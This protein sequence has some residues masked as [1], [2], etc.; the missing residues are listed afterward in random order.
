V[1]VVARFFRLRATIT[2]FIAS[3]FGWENVEFSC[4]VGLR[5]GVVVWWKNKG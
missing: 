4:G 5:C 3:N 1:V 2:R